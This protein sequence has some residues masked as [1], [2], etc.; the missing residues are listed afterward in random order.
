MFQTE[1]ILFLQSFES[2]PLNVFFRI[3]NSVGYS[4]FYISLAIII[5][6]CINFRK[7]FYLLHVLLWTGFV[8]TFLKEYFALPR[9]C[10]VDLSVKLINKDYLNP[11]KFDSM[12]ASRFLGGLPHDVVTYFRNI[13]NYSHGLPSGHVSATTALWGAIYQLFQQRWVKILSIALV[14]LMPITRM[15][16][17]RHFLVDVLGGILIGMFFVFFFYFSVYKSHPIRDTFI[18]KV[19]YFSLAPRAV[20]QLAYLLILPFIIYWIISQEN[21]KGPGL[22][23]GLNVGFVLLTM[24]GLPLD[25]GSFFQKVFRF[26][27]AAVF[28]HGPNL[29]LKNLGLD[30]I[31]SL[32]FIRMTVASFTMIYFTTELSVKLRLYNREALNKLQANNAST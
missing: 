30:D 17:G 18:Q 2:D 7:G 14:V 29:L 12:G 32:E 11:T 10:D 3:I 16:L 31:P 9:P 26:L 25:G 13:E 21:A 23:L 28:Y 19:A 20:L 8:T 24:R 1:I 4:T 15:Y 22:L 6:F 27:I 5:M